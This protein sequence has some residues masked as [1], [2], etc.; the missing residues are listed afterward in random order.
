MEFSFLRAVRASIRITLASMKR[1]SKRLQRA[2]S[3]VF[4]HAFSLS[5]CQEAYARARGFRTWHEAETL[6]KR[7]G[8]D[9]SLPFWKI[10]TRNDAHEAALAALVESEL[11]LHEGGPV[12]FLG[13]Q[14]AAARPALCL[15]AETMSAMETTGLILVNTKA[16]SLQDTPLGRA[17]ADLGFN[18]LLSEFRFLD[19]R[20]VNL[21]VAL[22]TSGRD[23]ADCLVRALPVEE[24]QALE[25]SGTWSLLKN[26]LDG[27]GRKL[28][29]DGQDDYRVSA[30]EVRIA[31]ACLAGNYPVLPQELTSPIA[32]DGSNSIEHEFEAFKDDRPMAAL[33]ALAELA[34]AIAERGLGTGRIYSEESKHRPT[35]ILFDQDDP[36]SVV[37]AGVVHSLHYWRY[38]GVGLRFSGVFTRPII[39]F[40]DVPSIAACP[41]FLTSGNATFT[42]LVS[43]WSRETSDQIPG[44]FISGA[45]LVDVAEG[46]L[47]YSGR[48]T[49]YD[50]RDQ[51]E[52]AA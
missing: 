28:S 1:D 14:N 48:R 32:D 11:E 40:N 52:L 46:S 42:C 30:R 3:E 36:A 39:Y 17:A 10:L 15:W 22:S 23:W 7:G 26:M 41:S 27:M 43:G 47:V 9:R 34:Y 31:T 51:G 21:G 24:Q 20:E 38:V 12:I 2:S 25:K 37:V 4:G 49:K 29:A 5:A 35:V 13:D 8:R 50:I 19:A 33:R 45:R 6:L 44:H 18:E 16:Q